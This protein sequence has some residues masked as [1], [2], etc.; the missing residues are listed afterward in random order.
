LVVLGRRTA[1]ARRRHDINFHAQSLASECKQL[2]L[3]PPRL[4]TSHHEVTT[5]YSD[6]TRHSTTA[7]SSLPSP[8][9]TVDPANSL[10]LNLNLSCSRMALVAHHPAQRGCISTS[11]QSTSRPTSRP[12]TPYRYYEYSPTILALWAADARAALIDQPSHLGP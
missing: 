8:S 11:W 7:T 4:H 12:S 2:E 3:E 1:G 9:T 5:L 10:S 6:C